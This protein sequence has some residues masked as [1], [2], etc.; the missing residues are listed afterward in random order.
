M[1]IKPFYNVFWTAFV[2]HWYLC[3]GHLVKFEH[4]GF[5]RF[6]FSVSLANHCATG[7]AAQRFFPS[8]SG[9]VA[10]CSRQGRFLSFCG[11]KK[12]VQSPKVEKHEICYICSCNI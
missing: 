6:T 4:T 11:K 7:M 8:T 1:Q 10:V 5:L 2:G 9:R 3:F 12:C